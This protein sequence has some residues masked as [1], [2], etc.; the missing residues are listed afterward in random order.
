MSG[1][2]IVLDTNI[3]LYLLAGDETLAEF[4]QDKK[5]YV[6]V[7]TELELLGYQSI[8]SKEQN[9]IKQFLESCSIIDI[10]DD[11]KKIYVELRKKY[12]LKLGDAIAAATAIY[13]DLPFIT[14]DKDFGIIEELQLTQYRPD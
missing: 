10:N 1:N 6:S 5:G 2:R 4:L 9:H 11:V 8:T 7:L 13:L 12:R 14:A 3:V